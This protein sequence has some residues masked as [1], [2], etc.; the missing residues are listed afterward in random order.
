MEKGPGEPSPGWLKW[1]FIIGGSIFAFALITMGVIFAVIGDGNLYDYN[2]DHYYDDYD[3]FDV[4]VNLYSGDDSLVIRNQGDPIDWYEYEVTIDGYRVYT[5]NEHSYYWDS[6][7]F[8][9]DIDIEP[10]TYYEVKIS[11]QYSGNI[12][13]FEDI[14]SQ[15][16][17][18]W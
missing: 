13:F 9:C 3:T 12:V 18:G 5:Y 17:Y 14:Y 11:N 4:E 2:D 1:Y 7:V 16:G 8:E 15:S 6:S 10:W